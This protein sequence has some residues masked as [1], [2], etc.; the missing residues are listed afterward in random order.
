MRNSANSRGSVTFDQVFR[1][2]G[3]PHRLQ[4]MQLL[5]ERE[6]SAGEILEALD[7][8]QSTLS[9]HMKS[10]VDAEVVNARR[11]GKWTYYSINEEMISAAAGLLD[12]YARGT[13]L[14]LKADQP[15][16]RSAAGTAGT[17]RDRKAA[18][19]SPAK[20]TTKKTGISGKETGK[21]TAGVSKSEER[22]AVKE[23]KGTVK[24]VAKEKKA[25]TYGELKEDKKA[26]KARKGKKNKK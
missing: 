24:A 8:V 15:G 17:R 10:L 20:E 11:S 18:A 22:S 4:I 16:V 19:A 3:D 12:E 21:S 26:K 23:K 14:R 2:I 9:H 13:K 5:R 7:V 6:M 25:Q 1:A